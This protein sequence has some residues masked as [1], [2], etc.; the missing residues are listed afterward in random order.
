[1]SRIFMPSVLTTAILSVSTTSISTA[2][3]ADT[4]PAA[5]PALPT[6][7][8][9][10]GKTPESIE[11]V[12]ARISVIDEKT[13]QQSPIADLGQLLQ[14]EAALN[15]VQSGGIGQ[16]TSIF[17]RGTNSNHTLLLKDGVRL[18]TGSQH[19]ASLPFLDLTDI[20]RIEVLKGPASVQYG[21]DAVGG[22]VQ[23]ITEPPKSQRFFTTLEAGDQQTYKT[24]LGADLVQEDAYLQLRGQRLESDG[25]PVTNAPEAKN[26]GFDQKGY[27]AKG[28]IDN[29]QYALGAEISENK[30]TSDYDLF[31]AP[32]SQDFLNRTL[33][34]TGRYQL[35]EQLAVAARYSRFED[36][37]TQNDLTYLYDYSD[38]QN[39]VLL[40]SEID[41]TNTD[42]QEG[43]LNLKWDFT[44][45]QNVLAGATL[46]STKIDSL[47]SG[48]Q[49]RKTL[50]S[51]GYY[52]QHQYQAEGVSTQAGIRV[53]D[54]EQFGTHTVGQLA[55]RL[56]IAPLTSI[57]AN[58]G[59]AFKAPSGND[60]YGYGGNTD[61]KPEESAS[62]ELGLDHQLTSTLNAY[63]SVYRTNIK[64]LIN[65]DPVT[66]QMVNIDKASLTGGEAGLKWQQ[67]AWFGSAEYAYVQPK[68]KAT[69]EDLSRRP[70]QIATLTGGWDNT[71]YG[72]SASLVAKSRS[73]NSAYDDIKIPGYLSAN[74]NAF[75][76]VDQH[77]RLFTNLKNITDTKYKTAYG[78]GAYYIASPL[79]VTAGITLSY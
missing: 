34:L 37:L 76:Q 55:G 77:V 79:L 33:N 44:A 8:L 18:N 39:P 17:T 72:L 58:I 32:T 9:T 47:S 78:S 38:W 30:G 3:A 42:R 63:A 35:N 29:A 48:T 21:S 45:N 75:W 59:T 73:D 66:Y 25:S 57:Y 4:L 67:D 24:I 31:G 14:R 36:Q 49:Y 6:I 64:N 2:H 12:P 60:L 61:L 62:Y 51:F 26:A 5:N 74:V 70:R 7:V 71:V 11:Q 50:D 52:L 20:N 27:S 13:I 22:V 46:L 1:M 28:G 23:L 53:E 19:V 56:Q 65:P 43:D 41:Y 10:A 15:V 16:I 68:D 69:R 54:S 40:G